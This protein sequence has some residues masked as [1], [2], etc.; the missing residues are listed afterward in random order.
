M[1]RRTCAQQE[2]KMGGRASAAFMRAGITYIY[3]LYSVILTEYVPIE[4]RVCVRLSVRASVCLS[5]CPSV[6]ESSTA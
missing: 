5:V 1:G 3:F 2:V 4:P 6:C